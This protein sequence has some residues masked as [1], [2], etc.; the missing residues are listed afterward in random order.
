MNGTVWRGLCR[1]ASLVVFVGSD[2]CKTRST[3]ASDKEAGN[4][5]PMAGI[6]S[7]NARCA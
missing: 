1:R 7:V 2:C 5:P 4:E 3:I 6:Q